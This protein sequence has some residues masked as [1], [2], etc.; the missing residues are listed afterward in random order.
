MQ[1]WKKIKAINTCIGLSSNG[2][3]CGETPRGFQKN[4]PSVAHSTTRP[5]QFLHAYD[6]FSTI[7]HV[8]YIVVP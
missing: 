3:H 7:G 6:N 2:C 8:L 4:L 5:Q 1:P